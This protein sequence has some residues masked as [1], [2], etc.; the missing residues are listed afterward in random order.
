MRPFGRSSSVVVVALVLAACGG[1]TARPNPSASSASAPASAPTLASAPT[2]VMT[3]APTLADAPESSPGASAARPTGSSPSP[4][5][6]PAIV[7][8]TLFALLPEKVAG[9]PIVETP[10]AEG[11]SVIE[12]AIARAVVRLATGYAVSASGSDWA[13]VSVAA[14]RPGVWSDGFFRDWRDTYDTGVCAQTGGIGGRAAV[15]IAGR[16]VEITS[17]GALH[18]YHVH[19]TGRDVLLS[20]T[21]VGDTRFGEQVVAGLRP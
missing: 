7:D 9:V 15:T 8:P 4:S 17:C 10:E 11:A 18:T 1:S 20:V 3:L 21:S 13:V 19:L 12:P 14:L 2:P 5:V 16:D 6:A